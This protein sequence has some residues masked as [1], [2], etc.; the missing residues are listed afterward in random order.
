MVFTQE[1]K[2]IWFSFSQNCPGC[3][4][5]NSG[6]RETRGGDARELERR[7]HF[8]SKEER[9]IME[10]WIFL[11]KENGKWAHFLRRVGAREE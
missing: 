5:E 1:S 8:S 3:W 6:W 2:S 7:C 9:K 10:T 4:V 11:G